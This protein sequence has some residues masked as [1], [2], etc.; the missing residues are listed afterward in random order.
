MVLPLLSF[1]YLPL[2]NIAA[3][4]HQKSKSREEQRSY[5]QTKQAQIDGVFLWYFYKLHKNLFLF[6]KKP[7]YNE[8]FTPQG[9]CSADEHV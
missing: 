9:F 2:P 4:W 8:S 6:Q 5:C 3:N 7:F 1:P